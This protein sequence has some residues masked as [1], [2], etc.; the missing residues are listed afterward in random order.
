MHIILPPLKGGEFEP[1][2]AN[3]VKLFQNQYIKKI[4]GVLGQVAF[5]WPWIQSSVLKTKQNL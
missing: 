2:Q 4:A 3:L 1:A 5:M